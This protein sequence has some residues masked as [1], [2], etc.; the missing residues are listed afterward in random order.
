MNPKLTPIPNRQS[1][2]RYFGRR[3]ITGYFTHYVDAP[4]TRE[5]KNREILSNTESVNRH[6]QPAR[7]FIN[8]SRTCLFL[9]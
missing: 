3:V 4:H 6:R 5:N 8:T 9:P 1:R 2:R 7:H